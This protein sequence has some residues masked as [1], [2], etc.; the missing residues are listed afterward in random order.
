ME[1]IELAEVACEAING[2]MDDLLNDSW[3]FAILVSY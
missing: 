1:P 3:Q 2:W